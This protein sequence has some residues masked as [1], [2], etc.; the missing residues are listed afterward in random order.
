M[1][2]LF[3]LLSFRDTQ[4]FI[5]ELEHHLG[6]VSFILGG[7]P[8]GLRGSRRKFTA[9]AESKHRAEKHTASSWSAIF[10]WKSADL[11]AP[12]DH[13]GHRVPPNLIKST[14]ALSIPPVYLRIFNPYSLEDPKLYAYSPGP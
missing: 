9:A 11:L 14:R 2:P 4:P 1:W 13:S 8:R 5:E 12:R 10:G 3:S 7:L 6:K